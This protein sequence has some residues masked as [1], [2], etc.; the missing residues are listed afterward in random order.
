MATLGGTATTD[1]LLL[2]SV[3]LTPPAGAALLNCSVPVAVRP[4]ATVT[5]LRPNEERLGAPGVRRQPLQRLLAMSVAAG[6]PLSAPVTGLRPNEERL[7]APGVR[8]QT[9]PRLLAMSVAAS[10]PLSASAK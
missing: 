8:R 6:Q 9:L 1:G 7:G 10:Q 5:G 3:I 4:L 2:E